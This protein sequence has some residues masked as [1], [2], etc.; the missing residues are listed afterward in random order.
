[1]QLAADKESLPEYQERLKARAFYICITVLAC[2][3]VAAIGVLLYFGQGDI[4]LA[5][6]SFAAGA[7]AVFIAKR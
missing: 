7:I 5:L 1:M 2:I 3:S 6:T 4:V